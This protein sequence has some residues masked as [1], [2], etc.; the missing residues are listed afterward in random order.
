MRLANVYFCK[1]E[2]MVAA[3]VAGS[4]NME[5]H[6]VPLHCLLSRVCLGRGFA[7]G[8]VRCAESP[9]PAHEHLEDEYLAVL[10]GDFSIEGCR[11][12]LGDY[13]FSPRGTRHEQ[14]TTQS[15]CLLLLHEG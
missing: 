4:P 12:E 2:L 7:A 9:D 11:Y 5:C 8:G 14:G 13:L 3:P 10:A 1:S 15:G 6:D